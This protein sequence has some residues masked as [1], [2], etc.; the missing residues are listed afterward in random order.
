MPE[1]RLNFE[2]GP[3]DL[4]V[5]KMFVLGPPV[6]LPPDPAA[7]LGQELP[8]KPQPE[9]V[10]LALSQVSWVTQ[11]VGPGMPGLGGMPGVATQIQYQHNEMDSPDTHAAPATC[12]GGQSRSRPKQSDFNKSTT[13]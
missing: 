6:L 9:V 13:S 4:I 5:T 1:A 7:A 12:V 8:V 11:P 2:R 3:T 10:W